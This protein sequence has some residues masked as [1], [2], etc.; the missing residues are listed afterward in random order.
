[1]SIAL[2]EL[3]VRFGCELH[4]DPQTLINHVAPLETAGPGALSFLANPKLAKLLAA[5]KATAVIVVPAA[6]EFCPV[7]A[8][9]STNPHVLFARI[10]NVIYPPPPLK[11]GIH[12]TAIV[13]P[14]AQVDPTSEVAP[15]AVIGANAVI[16]ERCLIGPSCILGVGVRVGADSRLIARV[17]LLQGVSLGKRAWIHPGV[18]IGADG[19]GLARA[20]DGWV[21]VPQ[22]GSV[23]IGDDVE[24]G[25]NTTID[26]GAMADTVIGDGVKLDNQIQIGH[27]VTIGAHT[28]IAGCTGV[29]GST[30]IGQRCVIGG[31]VG[32]AGH[33]QIC[34]DVSIAGKSAVPRSIKEPGVY[35]G[36]VAAEPVKIWNRIMGRMKMDA[37]RELR[38]RNREQRHEAMRK[39]QDNE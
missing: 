3:A 6:L 9:V 5:T 15:H 29:A 19:F 28:A 18:V 20:A 14:S 17:T 24:I 34:D 25:A 26:R 36:V 12:P 39:E 4:G 27:N 22:I 37:R 23:R 32:F 13:D 21:K 38:L 2:G 31:H 11:P 30:H 8:L 35:S 16:D 7:A 10:A 1:M 33:I